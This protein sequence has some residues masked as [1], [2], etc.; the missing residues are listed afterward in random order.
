MKTLVTGSA[1][2]IGSHLV[3]FLHDSQH[4]SRLCG[5]DWATDAQSDSPPLSGVKL[6]TGDIRDRDAVDSLMQQLKPQRIYH[7]AA[8]S[9][10][11]LSWKE[12]VLTS[13][14][15]IIGTIHLFEAILKNYVRT[16]VHFFSPLSLLL[17][18]PYRLTRIAVIV[19]SPLI[20]AYKRH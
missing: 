4:I 15:N 2:F 7:L 10:P 16:N 11:T 17:P 20:W 3:G 12:P 8:Q 19:K 18:T 6:V 13:Q 1:G 9:F 5:F 14:T